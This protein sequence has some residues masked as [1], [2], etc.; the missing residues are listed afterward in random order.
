[1]GEMLVWIL[2]GLAFFG[3]AFLCLTIISLVEG[4]LDWVKRRWL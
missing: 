3:F 1:M 4:V 2:G